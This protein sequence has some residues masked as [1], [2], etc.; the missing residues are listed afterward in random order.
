MARMILCHVLSI[1]ISRIKM[2]YS[3][4]EYTVEQSAKSFYTQPRDASER[5]ALRLLYDRWVILF[6]KQKK[7]GMALMK[8]DDKKA[9]KDWQVSG[10]DSDQAYLTWSVSLVEIF[11]LIES[12]AFQV[13]VYPFV[14]KS[15]S[16]SCPIMFRI[17]EPKRTMFIYL[18]VY[19]S[20]FLSVYLVLCF[21]LFS[22]CIINYPK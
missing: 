8:L 21:S 9:A 16:L 20:I 12:Q 22:H 7:V 13:P 1:L 6:E 11:Q 15:T 4:M 19:L 10:F 2:S 17:L 5:N 14:H 3:R 18:S